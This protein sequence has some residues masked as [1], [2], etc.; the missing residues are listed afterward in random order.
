MYG[1]IPSVPPRIQ[2]TNLSILSFV[3]KCTMR[4]SP[5]FPGDKYRV[6]VQC[7]TFGARDPKFYKNIIHKSTLLLLRDD[8]QSGKGERQC[9][10]LLGGLTSTKKPP[11][12]LK[13]AAVS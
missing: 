13:M 11:F 7:V 12:S 4:L 5:G 9:K 1:K 3:T 8:S 6:Q 2:I 10:L